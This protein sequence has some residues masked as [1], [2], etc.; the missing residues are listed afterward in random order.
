MADFDRLAEEYFAETRC[1]ACRQP[2]LARG[3]RCSLDRSYKTHELTVSEWLESLPAE[4][5]CPPRRKTRRGDPLASINVD[6]AARSAL[7]RERRKAG[8]G[9]IPAQGEDSLTDF[10]A[11]TDARLGFE[12]SL[13]VVPKWI[14]PVFS[15]APPRSGDVL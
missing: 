8:L 13:G 9:D 4:V 3:C 14:K 6:A 10:S 7:S 1:S 2:V 15:Q 12:A 5:R 11:A